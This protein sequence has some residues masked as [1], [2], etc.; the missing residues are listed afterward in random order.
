LFRRAAEVGRR[1]VVRGSDL[2]ERMGAVVQRVT[3]GPGE[4]NPGSPVRQHHEADEK[5]PEKYKSM[6][7]G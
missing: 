2:R 5:E 6:R 1:L 7:C 3:D 4:L